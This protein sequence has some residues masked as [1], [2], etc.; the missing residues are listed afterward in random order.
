MA[1]A[2]SDLVSPARVIR[3]VIRNA[4]CNVRP[5]QELID[6]AVSHQSERHLNGALLNASVALVD[7]GPRAHLRRLMLEEARYIEQETGLIALDGEEVV[8][9]FSTICWHKSRWQ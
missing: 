5:V 7:L 6:G 8:P 2:T 1:K 4:C 9:P 3:R